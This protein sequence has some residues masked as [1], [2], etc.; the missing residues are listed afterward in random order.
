[1][2]LLNSF[3]RLWRKFRRSSSFSRVITVEQTLD[4]SSLLD[5][6]TLILVASDEK[7]KWL[8]L[9]CPCGCGDIHALNLMTSFI[10]RWTVL[11]D[12][13][14]RLTVS[15]SVKSTRCGAHF[16]IRT[17]RVFWC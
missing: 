10:P 12:E 17:N 13:S 15:P 4:P 6:K 8:K 5:R 11:R 9:K 16:F 14:D 7:L 2:I 3:E 1:M